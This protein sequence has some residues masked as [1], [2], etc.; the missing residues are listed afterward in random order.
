ME[1]A[2]ARQAALANPATSTQAQ[3]STPVPGKRKPGR[4][5]LKM[6]APS[7][8]INGVCK[9]PLDEYNKL[10]FITG[11]PL[12]FKN[13]ISY[14]STLKAKN[15]FIKCNE[16]QII[17][18]TYNT[19]QS[20]SCVVSFPGA[21]AVRYY[22]KEA[23]CFEI[24]VIDLEYAVRFIDKSVA[25][26]SFIKKIDESS[27]ISISLFTPEVQN[28]KYLSLNTFVSDPVRY[29]EI[30]SKI[31]EFY[32]EDK[33][34]ERFSLSFSI[35]CP[36]IKK[37]INDSTKNSKSQ[38]IMKIS[39][40]AGNPLVITYDNSEKTITCESL[41]RDDSLINL[42]SKLEEGENTGGLVSVS[43]VKAFAASGLCDI[44]RFD[45]KGDEEILMRNVNNSTN[46]KI[47]TIIKPNLS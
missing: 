32:S 36:I 13:M 35:K 42:T 37:D 28:E 34:R 47:L 12:L 26:L 8:V 18:Y 38:A 46:V 30:L 33:I 22:C 9:T 45:M 2:L 20:V 11:D 23:D 41:Y 3:A 21:S 25:K 40:I 16:S 6:Q 1:E 27:S 4:P 17:F 31:D 44:M 19:E 43:C 24:S 14:F 15:V 5:P 7:A 39:K 10:E 29:H